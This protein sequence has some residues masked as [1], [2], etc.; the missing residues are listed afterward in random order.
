M[1]PV[2][3][4]AVQPATQ[5]TAQP[6]TLAATQPAMQTAAQP[7]AHSAAQPAALAATQPATQT[8]VQ[9]AAHSATQP[10][11]S[12]LAP[13]TGAVTT[14]AVVVN[15]FKRIRKYWNQSYSCNEAKPLVC[16]KRRLFFLLFLVAFSEDK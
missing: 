6:A 1:Q 3:Q 9:P 11:N 13:A 16:E 8:A 2:T 12:V 4:T 7:A 5:P 15:S 14:T 10:A